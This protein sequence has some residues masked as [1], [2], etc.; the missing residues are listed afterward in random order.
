MEKTNNELSVFVC[1]ALRKDISRDRIREVLLQAGWQAER[2]DRA[3]E[4]YAEIDL[5]L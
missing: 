5:S 2:V 4:E 3:L 1:E